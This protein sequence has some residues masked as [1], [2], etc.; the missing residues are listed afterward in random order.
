MIA[1]DKACADACLKETPLPNTQLTDNMHRSDFVD[2]HDHFHNSS[3]NNE[4]KSCL[5]HAEKIGLGTT[6]YE[7][8]KM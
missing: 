6:N 8:I 5:A 3:P 7:L 4:W 2:H 1:L